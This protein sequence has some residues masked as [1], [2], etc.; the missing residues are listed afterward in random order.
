MF[1][2]AFQNVPFC[3]WSKHIDT[4]QNLDGN[5]YILDVVLELVEAESLASE[6]LVFVAKSLVVAI[7][8][9]SEVPELQT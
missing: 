5:S 6:G 2:T 4:F 7:E 3:H 8:R 9:V 1:N